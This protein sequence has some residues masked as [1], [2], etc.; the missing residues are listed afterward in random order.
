MHT[1]FNIDWEYEKTNKMEDSSPALYITHFFL[2]KNQRPTKDLGGYECIFWCFSATNGWWY[3]RFG[4]SQWVFC[5]W[6]KVAKIKSYKPHKRH[7]NVYIVYIYSV[8]VNVN[9]YVYTYVGLEFVL[10]CLSYWLLTKN[11]PTMLMVRIQIPWSYTSKLGWAWGCPSQWTNMDQL[12]P[13][14]YIYIYQ[15]KYKYIYIYSPE[16]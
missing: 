3:W 5:Q 12:Y 13:A 10:I 15:Q 11:N 8:Y 16:V 14:M 6:R 9:I 7:L 2:E 4:W 1:P